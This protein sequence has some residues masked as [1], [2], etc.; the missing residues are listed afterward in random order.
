METV[1]A[2]AVTEVL[3]T[4]LHAFLAPHLPALVAAL[5]HPSLLARS[6]AEV[7][8][9]LAT[10][11]ALVPAKLHARLLLPALASVW[12]TVRSAAPEVRA[13]VRG[14]RSRL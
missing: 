3:V 14:C 5:I 13:A 8:K 11:E 7:Q 9:R 4:A 10:L 12:A 1:A 6:S 2:L